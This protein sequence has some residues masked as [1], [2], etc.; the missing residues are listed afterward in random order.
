MQ[1]IE[2]LCQFITRRNMQIHAME[3]CAYSI[4]WKREE[5]NG[6]PQ[7]VRITFNLG[8]KRPDDAYIWI[9]DRVVEIRRN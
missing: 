5:R 6:D 2:L 8:G 7:L 3:T 4:G 1:E 9:L